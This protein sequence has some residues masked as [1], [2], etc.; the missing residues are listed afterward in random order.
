[1]SREHRSARDPCQADIG[2]RT[3][4]GIESRRHLE[5]L[6]PRC[7]RVW[8]VSLSAHLWHDSAINVQTLT[9]ADGKVGWGY[10]S[11][12]AYREEVGGERSGGGLGKFT[13]A[14]RVVDVD[15][16]AVV[17]AEVMVGRT[18]VYKG[19]NGHYGETPWNAALTSGSK[20]SPIEGRET[21]RTFKDSS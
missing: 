1:M 19:A 17:D 20:G 2:Q 13:I 16:N 6:C 12:R 9:E 3:S 10:G 4:D 15:G 7:R 11:T 8:S 5:K 14:G 21:C 18:M